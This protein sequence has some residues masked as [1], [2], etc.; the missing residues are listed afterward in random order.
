M[1]SSLVHV[2]GKP[3]RRMIPPAGV[4]GDKWTACRASMAVG[5]GRCT[6]CGVEKVWP[7][8]S[9]LQTMSAMRS[10]GGMWSRKGRER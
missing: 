2:H 9:S 7:S 10:I 8:M 1:T 4:A 3:L 6:D 5:V